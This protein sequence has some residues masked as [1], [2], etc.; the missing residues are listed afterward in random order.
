MTGT[1]IKTTYSYNRYAG[2]QTVRKM[3]GQ[4][5]VS[6][7]IDEK[8]TDAVKQESQRGT[9]MAEYYGR[10]PQY[11]DKQEER[12]SL[13]YS[14]LSSAGLS[15]EGIEHMSMSEFKNTISSTIAGI[16]HHR[17][18]PYDEETVLITEE[19]WEKMKKDT[20]YTAW[21][22]GVIKEDRSVS[23]PF[24]GMGDKGAFIMQTFGAS[25]SDY[26]GQSFSK[27]YGGTAAGARS[28]Y[29]AAT[30]GG[31][32]TRGLQAD[33]QPMAD[34]NLWEEKR[35]ALQKKR[36]DLIEA[37]IQAKYMQKKRLEEMYERKYYQNSIS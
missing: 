25:P 12:M 37:D 2:Y 34:Y 29:K 32:V 16:P 26:K 13:G 6:E 36:K 9:V 35:R 18:R 30:E 3:T 23:N 11:K 15:V 5:S 10:K 1:S 27:I 19:G 17:T 28:A 8:G 22:V 20:D 33:F 31:I 24:F 21:V 4:S 7:K 14:V